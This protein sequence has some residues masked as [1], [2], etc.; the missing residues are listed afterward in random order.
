MKR[1]ILYTI[2][3]L[4]LLTSGRAEAKIKVV[5]TLST[6]ADLVR[7][8]GR[9]HV[10]VAYIAPP[11]FNPHFIEPKPSDVLK[12]MRADLFV[13]AGLDL[14]LWRWPL[15]DAAGKAEVRPGGDREL[16]LSIGI[17]LLEVP[18]Q[19][20]TRA[21]GDIHIYGNPHYWIHPENAK[22]MGQSICDKLCAV[23]AQHCEEY[24]QN[25]KDFQNRLDH[26]I[27]EW[28][29]SFA[30]H[31]GQ[32]LVG[33]HNQW[34]YLMEFL[35][36]KMNYFLEPK[37]GIPPTPKQIGLVEQR[38]REIGIRAIIQA[39]FLP[40][41]ASEAVAKRTG[42]K[43]VFLYEN[44]GELPEASDYISMMDYNIRE[45]VRSLE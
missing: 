22:I 7:T 41:E 26:K 35:G 39:T 12:V 36:L 43:V 42:S 8:V 10:D 44:V 15:V 18:I 4:M 31:Q 6:F 33:Y 37:P 28:K 13:H 2:L 40:K 5:T 32:E 17:K 16:D 9:E 23:D 19:V 27:S 29:T 30:P 1:K 45:L 24:R 3:S 21:A 38:I 34:P 11:R 14:E 25:L 20:L